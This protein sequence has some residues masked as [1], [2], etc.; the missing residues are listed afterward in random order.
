MPATTAKA[1]H[2]VRRDD[3][4]GTAFVETVPF[5]VIVWKVAPPSGL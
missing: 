5:S 4:S 3:G 2:P 1:M